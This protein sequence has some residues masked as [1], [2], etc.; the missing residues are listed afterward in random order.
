MKELDLYEIATRAK[1][2]AQKT[3]GLWLGNWK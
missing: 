2:I 1:I 3:E